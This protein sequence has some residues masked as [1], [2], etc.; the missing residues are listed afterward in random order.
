MKKLLNARFII[1]AAALGAAAFIA[2]SAQATVVWQLNPTQTNGPAGSTTLAYT[3][4]GYTITATGYD[5]N[6]GIGTPTSLYLKNVGPVN[7]AF[8]TGLGVVNTADHELQA[9][10]NP[11]NPFDFIQLDLS[12][13]LKAGATSGGVSVVSVQAGES[14]SIYGSNTAGT[15]GTQLGGSFGSSFDNTFVSLPN[16]GE[17]NFYSIVATAADVLPAAVDANIPAVP[18]MN[19][20][21]PVI[22]LMAAVGSTH[23]LRR[24]RA[25]RGSATADTA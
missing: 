12:M 8:E 7:G 23:L 20:L 21:F 25:L 10:S 2:S 16:F 3:S 15:L 9:G 22:G 13:I 19:A 17:Y 4:Q 24:R 5:N 1:T 14:F 11:S 6:A 18:E